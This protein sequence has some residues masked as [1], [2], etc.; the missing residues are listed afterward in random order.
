MN[1]FMLTGLKISTEKFSW[2]YTI[3]Q[4]WQKNKKQKP[5]KQETTK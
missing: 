3:D 1:I 5:T 2:K 4:D